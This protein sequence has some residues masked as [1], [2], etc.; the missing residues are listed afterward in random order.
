MPE[1]HADLSAD[2][3]ILGAGMG[4]F[5]AFTSLAKALRQRGMRKKVI[6]VD[7][8]DTFVFIPLLHEV[9]ADE[10]SAETIGV[11]LAELARRAGQQFVRARVEHIDT[12]SRTVRTSA[13]T[14][15]YNYCVVALGSGVNYLN[16][17]GARE[18]SLGL[19]TLPMALAIRQ[20]I[21]SFIKEGRAANIVIVG[22]GYTGVELAGELATI[23][24]HFRRAGLRGKTSQLSLHLVEF[25][26]RVLPTLP[27]AAQRKAMRRLQ[28]LGV[29]LHMRASAKAVFPDRV[30]L[31]DSTQLASDL[32]I[33]CVGVKSS[34]EQFL[35]PD[36]QTKGRIAV[37]S[38]LAATNNDHV[39]AIGDMALGT[40]P[41]D[42]QPYPQLG[43]V[44]YDQGEY[45]GRRL[46][47]LLAGEK[48]AMA[49]HFTL[50]GVLVPIG[51]G[52]GLGIF[53]TTI[54]EGFLPWMLRKLVFL[55]YLP[56]WR[57][58]ML[59]V[60]RWLLHLRRR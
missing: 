40:N 49:F 43:S 21:G 7:S 47:A 37:T 26:E 55:Y 48:P 31:A 1:Q 14:I 29:M 33:W 51:K 27:E 9:T 41:D 58:K 3:V 17:P 32:T 18:Q 6:L 2:V 25:N 36:L 38:Y 54:L 13:G 19:R 39:Y 59:L 5:Y 53:G 24:R 45:V 46:A 30:E 22:G 8:Q 15:A 12:A 60:S 42:G 57:R 50:P 23:A 28:A 34:A 4:G 20:R 56:G 11:P 10:V 16:I 52:Y 35:D 44:A